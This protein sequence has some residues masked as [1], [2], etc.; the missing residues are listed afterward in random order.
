MEKEMKYKIRKVEIK[1]LVF[2]NDMLFSLETQVK[3]NFKYYYSQF[4]VNYILCVCVYAHGGQ[5]SF[6][7]TLGGFLSHC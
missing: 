3:E 7:K 2:I 1:L 4:W 6:V 5:M